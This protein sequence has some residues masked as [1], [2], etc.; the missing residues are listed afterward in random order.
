VLLADNSIKMIDMVNDE[1]TCMIKTLHEE[2]RI[3]KICPN[4]KYI[5]TGGNKGDICIWAIKKCNNFNI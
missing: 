4:G 1:N 5:L 3:L 2:S